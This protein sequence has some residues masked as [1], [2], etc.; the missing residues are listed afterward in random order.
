MK[1]TLSGQNG[2]LFRPHFHPNTEHPPPKKL[3]NLLGVGDVVNNNQVQMTSKSISNNCSSPPCSS[4]SPPPFL[5]HT[6][7]SA[8][9][10][11]GTRASTTHKI[12]LFLENQRRGGR[13][14]GV[15]GENKVRQL[16]SKRR[17]GG[18]GYGLRGEEES[19]GAREGGILSEVAR[20]ERLLA[21]RKTNTKNNKNKTIWSF[22]EL[23]NTLKKKQKIDHVIEDLF[24]F[25]AKQDVQTSKIETPL[26]IPTQVTNLKANQ[27]QGRSSPPATIVQK[28]GGSPRISETPPLV[29]TFS[30]YTSMNDMLV[31]TGDIALEYGGFAFALANN[32]VQHFSKLH[33]RQTS[34]LEK[35]KTT[36][37]RLGAKVFKLKKGV[38]KL[39]LVVGTKVKEVSDNKD[40]FEKELQSCKDQVASS[41]KFLDIER[42]SKEE[43]VEKLKKEY[44]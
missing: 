25:K 19:G 5:P 3:K 7:L 24:A 28:A 6:T 8:P 32:F 36:D 39:K 12:S 20:K 40:S 16:W 27:N 37:K 22:W 15:R 1:S 42:G 2:S 26:V 33:T 29:Y 35:E 14:Y 30:H 41:Q 38:K 17:G 13:S 10:E 4:S 44:D 18:D 34:D 9:T 11:D 21:G 23:G 31:T 43:R